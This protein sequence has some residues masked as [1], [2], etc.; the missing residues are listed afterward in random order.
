[1]CGSFYLK[2]G[3]ALII[4]E[5]KVDAVEAM[6]RYNGC[7]LDNKAMKMELLSVPICHGN[8]ISNSTYRISCLVVEIVYFTV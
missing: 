5:Q 4:F 1:M 8:G 2:I 3:T 6:Q 7:L